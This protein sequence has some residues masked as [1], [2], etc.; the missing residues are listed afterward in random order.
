MNLLFFGV[1]FVWCG[2]ERGCSDKLK[3]NEIGL[4]KKGE[5][6]VIGGFSFKVILNGDE[7]F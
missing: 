6:L 7:L 2:S 5:I 4:L 1:I 3:I